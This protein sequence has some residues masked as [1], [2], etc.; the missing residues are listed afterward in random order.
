MDLVLDRMFETAVIMRFAWLYPSNYFVY[1]VI[2]VAVIF[3]FTTF[4]VA[5]AILK[6]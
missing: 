4:I 6:T 3:N 5:G 1:L 2:F